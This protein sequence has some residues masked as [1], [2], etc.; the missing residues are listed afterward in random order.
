L[1]ARSSFAAPLEHDRAIG[2]PQSVHKTV[3]G[4]SRRCEFLRFFYLAGP[5]ILRVNCLT[6]STHPFMGRLLNI[7]AAKSAE[8]RAKIATWRLLWNVH[9]NRPSLF[10]NAVTVFAHVWQQKLV[11]KFWHVAGQKVARSCPR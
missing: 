7:D 2:F 10:V 9:S 1:Q 8:D 3:Q 4:R 5:V 6:A 11:V